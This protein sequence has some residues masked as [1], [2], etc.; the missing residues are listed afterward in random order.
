M[1]LYSVLLAVHITAGTLGLIAAVLATVNKALNLP[2]WWHVRT[3]NT[4]VMAM[5]TIFITATAM[6][7][8]KPNVF[9]LLVGVFSFYM[10]FSGWRYAKN[11]TGK[12]T[13]LDW[14]T[15]SSMLTVSV[16]MIVFGIYLNTAGNGLGVVVIVFGFIGGAL[17]LT[18]YRSLR[19]GGLTGKLRI[20]RHLTMMLGGAIAALTAFTVVNVEMTPVFIPW[21]APTMLITPIIVFWNRKIRR[22]TVRKGM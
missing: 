11:R 3:G 4:F 18:D 15:V 6:S 16:I 20:T 5:A 2:H 7:L 12:P 14:L 8:L 17:S 9:L 21:L 10:A 22:G 19:K 13:L 1:T